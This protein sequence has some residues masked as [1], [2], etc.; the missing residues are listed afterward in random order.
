MI[1]N[2]QA[3]GAADKTTLS[4]QKAGFPENCGNSVT[5]LLLKCITL[6]AGNT[7]LARVRVQGCSGRVAIFVKIECYN[8]LK[9]FLKRVL[10]IG[11]VFCQHERHALPRLDIT[12]P[13]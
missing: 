5:S 9:K 12:G 7:E 4:G 6:P 2:E 3:S 13:D 1:K 11:Y 10:R 8:N